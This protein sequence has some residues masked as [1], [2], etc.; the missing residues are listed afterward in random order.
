VLAQSFPPLFS[1][2]LGVIGI[3]NLNLA[4][5][6]GLNCYGDF[7][8]VD[9]LMISTLMPLALLFLIFL[10][11]MISRCRLGMKVSDATD[12]E[13]L[14]EAQSSLYSSCMLLFLM[15]T[16]ILLPGTSN[17]IFRIFGCDNVDPD[18]SLDGGDYYLTADYTISCSSP[19]YKFGLAYAC[20]MILIYPIGVPALYFTL[21]YR[22]RHAIAE[23]NDVPMTSSIA[24]QLKPLN[25]LFQS[26]E[27]QVFII[28][29]LLL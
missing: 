14:F 23:R 10:Y 28:T 26:Y 20:V 5:E 8:F 7:D 18:N 21:L 24:R 3:V 1:A 29:L 13:A 9:Y 17:L 19:R 16:Y 2:S 4:Q 11:Y 15:V 25:F 6:L 12:P 22:N 27:P